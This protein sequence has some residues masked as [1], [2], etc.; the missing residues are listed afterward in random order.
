MENAAKA[1]SPKS[2]QQLCL[3][4]LRRRHG[5]TLASLCEATGWQAHSVRGFLSG[6]VKKKLGLEPLVSE[7]VNGSRRYKLPDPNRGKKP[8]RQDQA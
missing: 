6:T 7:S 2:K 1:E 8:M 5:A 3:D 4:L